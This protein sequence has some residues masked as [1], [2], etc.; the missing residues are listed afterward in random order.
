MALLLVAFLPW[1]A[2]TLTLND[3]LN[4]GRT[5][6]K[7]DKWLTSLGYTHELSKAEPKA[8]GNK[9]MKSVMTPEGHMVA[10]VEPNPNYVFTSPTTREK[11]LETLLSRVELVISPVTTTELAC[12]AKASEWALLFVTRTPLTRV[13]SLDLLKA[14]LTQ[15]FDFYL[16]LIALQQR[17]ISR[18]FYLHS[19]VVEDVYL[20]EGNWHKLF[21]PNFHT[22]TDVK[23][24]TMTN[25]DA[26]EGLYQIVHAVEL[27]R[28][29]IA[30]SGHSDRFSYQDPYQQLMYGFVNAGKQRARELGLDGAREKLEAFRDIPIAQR[31]MLARQ[32]CEKLNDAQVQKSLNNIRR[33]LPNAEFVHYMFMQ[34]H[35]HSA[36]SPQLPSQTSET[37]NLPKKS[38]LE[39]CLDLFACGAKS[40]RRSSNAGQPTSRGRRT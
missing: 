27:L 30:G 38:R 39:R 26:A 7:L 21:V 36:T 37:I 6:Q 10:L 18:G 16:G 9:I 25:E 13:T 2:L 17:M 19:I 8:Y 1:A 3:C 35:A 11:V 28:L 24:L 15:R 14:T 20:V 40:R 31:S 32:V 34:L 22:L 23:N 4:A 33:A 29:Y 5:H 12:F